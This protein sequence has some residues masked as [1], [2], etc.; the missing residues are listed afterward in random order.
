MDNFLV[1]ENPCYPVSLSEYGRPRKHTAKSDFLTCQ[2]ELDSSSSEPPEVEAKIIDGAAFINI[3]TP[4]TSR[5]FG[6]Y[7]SVK[8]LL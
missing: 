3:N 6:E 8:V 7:C 2:V 5:T 1:H 4:K